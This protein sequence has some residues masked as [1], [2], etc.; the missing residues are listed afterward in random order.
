MMKVL[1]R[2]KVVLVILFILI[3][4]VVVISKKY[5]EEYT[6]DFIDH[7][8]YSSVLDEER[9]IFVRLPKGY[10]KKK[11][12]PLI[13]KSDGNFN[14]KRWD[15]SIAKL[16]KQGDIQDSIVVAIPNL[17]W[18]DSLNRDLVPPYARKDVQIEEA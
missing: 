11:S 6:S 4:S 1:S 7:N 14:L 2:S 18:V 12:Y 8:L 17:F 5:I 3:V 9:K 16:S 10:D 13:I 15:E